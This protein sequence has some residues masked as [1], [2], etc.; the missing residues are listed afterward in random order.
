[1]ALATL[2]GE[3]ITRMRLTMPRVGA[4]VADVEIDSSS[5]P[6]DPVVLTLGDLT[7][8]GA[9]YSGG[10]PF[11]GRTRVRIVGGAG[12][13]RSHV[14]AK[15]YTSIAG[16]VSLS[17]VLGDAAREVG[18]TVVIP[19]D[20]TIGDAYAREDGPAS[21]LL[22]QLAGEW[23]VRDDGATVIASRPDGAI[24][25]AF[26]V[27][28]YDGASDMITIAS[29]TFASFRPGRTVSTS[30]LGSRRIG[31]VVHVVDRA[32]V[33][34]EL[35]SAEL[36]RAV[37]AA[38][39]ELD[40][41]RRFHGVFEYIVYEH[42][43]VGGTLDASPAFD[44]IGLPSLRTRPVFASPIGGRTQLLP[45]AR[46][47]VAFVNGDPSR[48]IV[49]GLADSVDPVAIELGAGDMAATEH[50]TTAEAMVAFVYNVVASI[51]G[52]VTAL[53]AVN[54]AIASSAAF[55]LSSLT[56]TVDALR[57]ALAAKQSDTNGDKPGIG[58]PR[59][60]TG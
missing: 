58:A 15:G 41:M 6:S 60:R 57:A 50:V 10:T 30:V 48:P 12:R 18:E 55:D 52:P 43:S 47:L 20:R 45:G 16:G 54:G 46:I 29:D 49:L 59:V 28:A 24:S 22:W 40:P 8:V 25:D 44:S 19:D 36:G 32:R 26:D 14:A 5:A 34:T 35:W 31:T 21:R 9:M 1:M 27:V 33:R 37:D 53:G 17:T 11:H 2:N 51:L 39:R 13:W 3:T 23:Y 42:L 38:V 7:L 4:W 56:G